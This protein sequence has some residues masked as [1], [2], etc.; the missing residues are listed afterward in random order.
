MTF[1]TLKALAVSALITGATP[2]WVALG[3]GG[4][5]TAWA[6]VVVT[7]SE[8]DSTDESGLSNPSEEEDVRSNTRETCDEVSDST[9][10]LSRC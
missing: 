7:T 2:M 1:K 4:S 10:R 5:S 9:T 3:V 6:D 8:E